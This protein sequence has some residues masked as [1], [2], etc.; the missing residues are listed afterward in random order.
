VLFE[1]AKGKAILLPND[2]Q[3]VLIGRELAALHNVTASHTL[4]HPRIKY[5]T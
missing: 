1:F 2:K 3:L 4:D 5:D